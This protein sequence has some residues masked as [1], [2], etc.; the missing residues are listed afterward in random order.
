MTP[1]RNNFEDPD[2]SEQVVKALTRVSERDRFVHECTVFMREMWKRSVKKVGKYQAKEIMRQIMGEKKPGP[3]KADE[4]NAL[5]HF[6]CSYI[7]HCGQKQSDEKIAK[8]LLKSKP[9]YVQWESGLILVA[10]D[11]FQ[12]EM[13][14]ILAKDPAAKR[15]PI[16][17][18]LPALEKRVERCRRRALD[19][20]V[21]PKEYAPKPYNRGQ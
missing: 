5:D 2:F 18:R 9:Y 15:T 12:T 17:I 8:R 13:D 11:E 14:S 3:S 21:L 10:S 1:I 20:G 19:D 7:S 6:I 4:D 16:N